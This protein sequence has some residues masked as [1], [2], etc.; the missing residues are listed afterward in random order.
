MGSG[1]LDAPQPDRLDPRWKQVIDLL[2]GA[3]KLSDEGFN[4]FVARE[5]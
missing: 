2:K 3:G 4:G 1:Q 5:T